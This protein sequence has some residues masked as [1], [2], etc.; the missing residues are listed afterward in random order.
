ME[1]KKNP[2]KDPKRNSWLFF[3]VGLASIVAFSYLAIEL[4]TY[5]KEIATIESK[6]DNSFLDEEV[7][8]TQQLNQ[9]PP[10]PPPP[11]P[12][13]EVIKIVEDKKEI[14]EVIIESTETNQDQKI[15]KAEKVVMVAEEV[16]VDVPFAIIEDVPVFPGCEKVAKEKRRD[17][18]QEKIQAHIRKNFTYPESAMDAGIQ[19]RVF[20]SFIIDKDGTVKIANLRG[21]DKS[22][23]KEAD[24]IMSKLPQMTPGKQRGKP[25]RMTMSIPITFKLDK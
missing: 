25:V 8:I 11:P 18:L 6:I 19:G 17:C 15:V 5:E 3:Q 23:E 24:R 21:P 13:P 7:P 20:V 14:K 9:P 10:P 12:A 4:K 1:F 2:E 16:E 22:L